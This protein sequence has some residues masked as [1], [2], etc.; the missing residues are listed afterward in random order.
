LLTIAGLQVPVIP[1]FDVAGSTGAVDPEQIGAIA[2]KLG[3][4]VGLTVTVKVAVFTHWPLFGIN[5]YVAVFV[6]LTDE[7]FQVPV[8]PL[9]DVVGSTG[10]VA[11]EQ[12]GAIVVNVGVTVGITVTVTVLVVAH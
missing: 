8:I 9:F 6:L 4:I 7:G 12:I 1:L 3:A 11:P 5:V 10:A 2:V